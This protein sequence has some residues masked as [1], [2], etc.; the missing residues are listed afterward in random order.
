[1]LASSDESFRAAVS[2][3]A[4][5][6]YLY[7]SWELFHVFRVGFHCFPDSFFN[8]QKAKAYRLPSKHVDLGFLH[9]GGV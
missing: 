9:L 2:G 1:M 6:S 4:F 5:F 7:A 8:R 3:S